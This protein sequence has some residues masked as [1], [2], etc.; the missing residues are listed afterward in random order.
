L[1]LENRQFR[2][3][4]R[5][6]TMQWETV[7]GLEVHV[8][9][10][11]RSKIF[12]GS[13][14]SFG[15]EPNVHANAV[16]LALP[17]TLPVVNKSAIFSAIKFGLA[18]GAEINKHS[19]FERKNYFYPDLPKGYQTSQMDFPIVGAGIVEVQLA[20]GTSK[21]IRI[22]HAHL[23]ED[24]GKSLHEDFHGCTGIDLN[25]AGTPLIEIVSEP[26]MRNAE[27]AVAYAKKLH[28]IVTSLGISDGEMSQGSMRFDVNISVRPKGETKL[29]TRTETKNLNS[30]KFMEDAIHLEV[31]RQIDI[32]EDGGTIKQETRLYNGDTG[33][34]RS[35]R[36]KEEAND[37]RYFPCPDLLPIEIDNDTI[38]KIRADLPELPD[39]R[40]TRVMDNY[41][42]SDY[43]ANIIASDSKLTDFFETTA[44]L[45]AD[46]KL[47]A[48]WTM[49]ELLAL[50]NKNDISI[51]QS[52]ISATQLG[53]LILRIKDGTI[54]GKIAKQVFEAM[55]NGEGDADTIINARGLKQVSDEG[56]IAKIV[57]DILAANLEQVSQFK[58][59]DESKRKKMTG[60]F[61]GQIMKASK[62]QANPELV[63]KLLM[64]KLL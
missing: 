1:A 6:F 10:A 27:E 24:A 40:K 31:E 42:L 18:V 54:S 8:Q 58:T 46:A 14:T 3:T 53:N 9:L 48:N 41:G 55:Y 5:A 25:R 36:S 39:Q 21:T 33:K 57:D 17:G 37:Y 11:T 49:G 22:H 16:D 52:P 64:Q 43:D 29:G 19:V 60:F 62:G 32:L 23:E 59:A 38:D 50:L 56:A 12:S 4:I 30:F 20:D 51:L 34:A 44:K 45:C 63:N 7:I 2:Q 15:A 35:M 13:S 26:D 47:A 61:V 28:S